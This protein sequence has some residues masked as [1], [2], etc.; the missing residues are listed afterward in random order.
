LNKIKNNNMDSNKYILRPLRK[1]TV[2]KIDSLFLILVGLGKKINKCD[3]IDKA[4]TQFRD[5]KLNQISKKK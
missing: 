5:R 1:E 3:I 4:V 2:E